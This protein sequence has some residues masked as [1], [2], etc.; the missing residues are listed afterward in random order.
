MNRLWVRLGLSFT[1][2][3]VVTTGVV[4]VLANR[5]ASDAF[6]LYASY[7]GAS[8]AEL[9]ESL[10]ALYRRQGTWHGVETVLA[11]EWPRMP[12]AGWVMSGRRGFTFPEGSQSQI[13]LADARGHV[14]FDFPR[15]RSE[16]HLT[17]DEQV[18]AEDIVVDGELVGRLVVALPT[19][20]AIPGPLEERFFERLRQLLLAGGLVAGTIGLLLGLGFSHS[21]SA[22]LQRLAAAARAVAAGDLSHRVAVQG[23]AELAEVSRAFND[24]AAELQQAEQLRQNL[25]A[26]VAH[27][28]RTPLTVLRG[29]LQA[30]L[31]DVYPANKREI[32]VLYDETQ[33]LSRLVDDVRELALADSGR[34]QMNLQAIDLKK[35][36]S[37]ACE[38]LTPSVRARDV[39][40][41]LQVP[42]GL[43]A[44]LAD[45]DRVAQVLYNL[46]VNA[47][48]HT[49]PGGT[50]TV[51]ACRVDGGA[52]V[53]VSDTGE[54][55]A[56]EH[57]PHVFDRF[58]RSDPARSR[59]ERQGGSTGLG[60]SIARSLVN[61]QGGRI[62]VDSEP[63]GGAV[64]HFTLPLNG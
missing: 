59:D 44:V 43:P 24:M 8:P 61:A 6:R 10:A 13:V 63:G 33:L 9:V 41:T 55:I 50:I 18:A 5:T 2:V 40:L 22:P 45:P 57:L 36:L 64:F 54:G 21:L 30:I 32:G 3:V 20:S 58:W 12:M 19:Q 49:P 14:L 56:P 48:Q 31:E 17:Y 38:S 27:E 15:S 52:E 39:S 29:N 46:L 7:A 1:L 28:L 35:T 34:L 42:E 47:L 11:G 26:D 53:V 60:L 37:A 23:S 4:A 51:T 16:R 25:M 62:W